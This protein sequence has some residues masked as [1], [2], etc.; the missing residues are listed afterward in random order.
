MLINSVIFVLQETLEA[1]LLITV[2]LTINHQRGAS[3]NWLFT[4][5]VA[6]LFLSLLYA[7]NMASIS[8]WFDYVGQEVV[9]AS[10]Q[11]AITLFIGLFA[12]SLRRVTQ[13][14]TDGDKPISRAVRNALFIAAS[15]SITCAITV[16]GSEILVYLR[17][18]FH[19][20][21]E[22]QSALMGSSIGF[23]I[24]LSIGVLLYYLLRSLPPSLMRLTALI[25][26]AMFAGNMLSQAALQLTQA[27]W[28][29]SSQALWN[30]SGWLSESSIAGRL[31]YA[32]IGYEATPSLAQ[33]ISYLLGAGLVLLLCMLGKPASSLS[34]P[35]KPAAG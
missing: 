20:T 27:D 29:S 23:A 11:T 7:V 22:L 14:Q 24:G 19:Q 30:T 33:V 15:G 5:L 21:T 13:N 26:L 8:E 17:G 6:G 10:L 34:D 16:E 35:N 1:A 12:L 28:I 25:L 32:L 4:G 3:L 31:L 18:F 2:L 9:N